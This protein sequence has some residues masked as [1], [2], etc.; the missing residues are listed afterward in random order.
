M[1]VQVWKLCG[2]GKDSAI[3]RLKKLMRDHCLHIVVLLGTRP[4]ENSMLTVP[5]KFRRGL[6]LLP[7]KQIRVF[8]N[9]RRFISSNN[10]IDLGFKSPSVT[11]LL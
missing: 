4:D 8:G 3:N 9:F 10:L 5:W 6:V 11:M 2:A 7:L 1:K